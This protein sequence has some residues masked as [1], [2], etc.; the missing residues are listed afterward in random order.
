MISKSAS[1]L[2]QPPVLILSFPRPYTMNPVD[3]HELPQL[4]NSKIGGK[5]KLEDWELLANLEVEIS[6]VFPS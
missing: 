4:P 1:G 6:L 5:Q 2:D 3:L